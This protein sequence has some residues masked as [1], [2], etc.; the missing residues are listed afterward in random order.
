MT[1]KIVA[2]VIA[3]LW[4]SGTV[5]MAAD[6]KFF[7]TKGKN[8]ICRVIKAV[9]KTPKTIA[10]PFDSKETAQA[11]KLKLCGDTSGKDKANLVARSDNE[12]L[13]SPSRS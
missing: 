10:G 11:E 13:P 4:L 1:G 2:V 12:R 7:I 9:E 5:A 8:G 3:I 6:I